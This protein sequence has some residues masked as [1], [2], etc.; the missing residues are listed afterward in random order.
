V[1]F[2]GGDCAVRTGHRIHDRD[3]NC[4][5]VDACRSRGTSRL[6]NSTVVRLNCFRLLGHSLI[7]PPYGSD[8]D[9]D[10]EPKST[11]VSEEARLLKDLDLSSRQE[12]VS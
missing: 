5:V 11:I 4:E 1:N 3:S 7:Q 12:T 6:P 10:S 8:S 9:S 2:G